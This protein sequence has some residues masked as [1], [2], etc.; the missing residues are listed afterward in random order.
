MR[1]LILTAFLLIGCS[2]T[3]EEQSATLSFSEFL[4]EQNSQSISFAH[5]S[6]AQSKEKMFSSFSYVDHS[7]EQLKGEKE[8][9]SDRKKYFGSVRNALEL[10]YMEYG[11]KKTSPELRKEEKHLRDSVNKELGLDNLEEIPDKAIFDYRIESEENF[12]RTYL[13]RFSNKK[14]LDDLKKFVDEYT[15]GF[16]ILNN[17]DP[18][19]YQQFY[20]DEIVEYKMCFYLALALF[21]KT[22]YQGQR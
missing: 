8:R 16:L 3:I 7:Y 5:K 10:M 19:D 6:K 1:F 2:S 21:F 13:A 17:D 15:Q 14:A 22:A 4:K 9:E 11:L 18:A 12:D 20:L